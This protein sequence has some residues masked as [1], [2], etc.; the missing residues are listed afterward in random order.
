MRSTCSNRRR[1]KSC[2][3]TGHPKASQIFRFAHG[4]QGRELWLRI[5]REFIKNLCDV[6][7]LCL[8]SNSDI[9]VG[10]AI[11]I[12]LLLWLVDLLSWVLE[13]EITYN[14]PLV[15]CNL[16][17]EF[18]SLEPQN[19]PT[20][21]LTRLLRRSECGSPGA[22][23]RCPG[24]RLLGIVWPCAKRSTKM[25]KLVIWEDIS[26]I[27]QTEY[28]VGVIFWDPTGNSA[29]AQLQELR[30]ALLSSG[31]WNKVWK[32]K[33]ATEFR[34]IVLSNVWVPRTLMQNLNAMVNSNDLGFHLT[35]SRGRL[36][37]L[38]ADTKEKASQ[39]Q[40]LQTCLQDPTFHN[41]LSVCVCVEQRFAK[42]RSVE[43]FFSWR[44]ACWI[45]S[46]CVLA[47]F[48]NQHELW[49]LCWDLDISVVPRVPSEHRKRVLS[50]KVWSEKHASCQSCKGV[51]QK[52]LGLSDLWW[53]FLFFV[54]HFQSRKV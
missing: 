6:S 5:Q 23:N 40:F 46:Y 26:P 7:C 12:A 53:W 22:L 38:W 25:R 35:S 13:V 50:F 3:F 4:L 20:K 15:G 14:W 36:H 28:H 49:L 1:T 44:T 43:L 31:I 16:R 51:E 24:F 37:V 11:W 32:P 48:F 39:E 33:E 29:K 52:I 34:E 42:R 8:S 45:T 21:R 9:T 30:W 47:W 19:M 10:K 54:F 17:Q 27:G 18:G 41:A 2:N